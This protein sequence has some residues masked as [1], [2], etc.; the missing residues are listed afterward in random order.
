MRPGGEL[1]TLAAT[2]DPD[3]LPY[4][5]DNKCDDCEFDVRCMTQSARARRMELVEAGA[6]GVAGIRM[7]LGEGW[8]RIL[9]EEVPG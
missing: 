4:C 8:K 6:V 5:L 7:F 1:E 2:P 3:T 9:E